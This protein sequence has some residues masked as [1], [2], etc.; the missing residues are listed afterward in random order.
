MA[1]HNELGKKGENLAC[2]YLA[3]Q[4]Y[5]VRFR[6]WTHERY[7]V[8]VIAEKNGTL[9][10]IEVKTRA[11]TRFGLPEADVSRKKLL[12]LIEAGEAF[13]LLYPQWRCIQFDILSITLDKGTPEYLL[14]EDV[15]V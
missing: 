5:S 14:I 1:L 8:D 3:R 4:G 12:N 9:H 11:S 10:F 15:Y 6:N 13:L 2:E 7:E